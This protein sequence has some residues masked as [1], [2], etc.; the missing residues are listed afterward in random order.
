MLMVDDDPGFRGFVV[1][2]LESG[3]VEAVEASNANEAIAAAR[4]RRPDGAILD[5]TLPG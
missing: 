4:S 5:V 1:S 2:L 3:G